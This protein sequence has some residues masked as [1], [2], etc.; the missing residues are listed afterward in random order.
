LRQGVFVVAASGVLDAVIALF[1]EAWRRAAR[2][3]AAGRDWA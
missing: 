3:H 2:W 1:D